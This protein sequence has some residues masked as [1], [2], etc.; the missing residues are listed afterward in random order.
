[1]GNKM[2]LPFMDS[3]ICLPYMGAKN[4]SLYGRQNVSLNGCQ[5]C[6]PIRA[7][8]MCPYMG[9]KNVSLHGPKN[10]SLYVFLYCLSS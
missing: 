10:V 1:M 8:K 4:V 2:S 9:A 5:K 7:P 3:E 6:V